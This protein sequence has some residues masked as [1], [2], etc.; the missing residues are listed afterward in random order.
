MKQL[1]NSTISVEATHVVELLLD[2]APVIMATVRGELRH[3]RLADLNVAQLRTLF[4]VHRQAGVSPSAV[5]EHLDL[6]LS[7]VSKLVDGLVTRGHLRRE[8]SSDDRRRSCLYVT[9]TGR[10]IVSASRRHVGQRLQERLGQLDETALAE[11]AA[12]VEH[13]REVFPPVSQPHCD[14]V[15]DVSTTRRK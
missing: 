10:E 6:T 14:H 15:P 7:S 5:A 1:N 3:R 2:T 12:G 11:V 9:R 8:I 4:F 13:L